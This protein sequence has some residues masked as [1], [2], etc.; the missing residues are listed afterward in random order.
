M[1]MREDKRNGKERVDT[2]KK[3]FAEALSE[4]D[5]VENIEEVQVKNTSSSV[6]AY[7]PLVQYPQRLVRP[8]TSTSMANF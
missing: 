1:S 4:M 3:V 7:K 5:K 2:K 8:E 6:K